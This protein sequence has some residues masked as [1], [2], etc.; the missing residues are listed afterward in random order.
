VGFQLEQGQA[1]RAYFTADYVWRR[2]VVSELAKGDVLPV[3]PFYNHDSLHYYWLPHLSSAVDYRAIGDP[4]QLDALL[5]S[6]SVLVDACF[7][8][9]LFGLARVLV[10]SPAAAALGVAT[11]VLLSSYEGAYSLYEHWVIGAP[12]ALVKSLNIDAVARWRFDAMPIDGLHRVLLYQPHHAEG[13]ALGFLGLMATARRTRTVDPAAFA[14]AGTLLGLST[15]VSSFGGLMFTVAAALHEGVAALRRPNAWRI[16]SHAAAAGLPLVLAAA[17][18]TALQYVDTHGEGQIIRLGLNRLAVH[19]LIPATVLSFGPM[20]IVGA[21]GLWCAWRQRLEPVSMIVSLLV[22]CVIFYFWVDIRDHQDVYVGWR[23]GH[24]TFI[25]CCALCGV[26]YMW[27]GRMARPARVALLALLAVVLAPAAPMTAI[28]LFNTQDIY[29]WANGPGFPWT[30]ILAPEEQ[31]AFRWIRTHTPPD[32]VFQ[33]DALQRD[34]ASWAYVPAFA[35]RRL[36]VGLPISM[37]PL[38]KYEQGVRR[39]AWIFETGSPHSAH[40]LARRNGIQY[41]LVGS[42]E[43]T[44]HPQVLERFDSAPDLLPLV[45]RNREISIYRVSP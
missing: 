12:M 45:F 3:N 8:A 16:A 26:A 9:L 5:L 41:L 34:V 15:L 7:I 18:V 17:L 29:N 11:G 30:L 1:Y 24:L 19:N 36:G 10:A 27:V 43:R 13:Y 32:A 14:V 20:L 42:P 31:E 22:T 37:V 25:A 28:D 39:A 38:F 44:R 2:A 23:V 21:V 4:D 33:V 6:Q 40:D 35:E